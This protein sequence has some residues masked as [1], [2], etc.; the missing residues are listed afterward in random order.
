MFNI[1]HHLPLFIKKFREESF[2]KISSN[3]DFESA[4]FLLRKLCHF[5]NFD[6]CFHVKAAEAFVYQLWELESVPILF[7]ESS[8]QEVDFLLY[9]EAGELLREKLLGV[10]HLKARRVRAKLDRG[11]IALR[12]RLEGCN[13]GCDPEDPDESLLCR[14]IHAASV[15]KEGQVVFRNKMLTVKDKNQLR[16]ASRYPLFAEL[17][18]RD[19]EEAENF[20]TWALRDHIA[21]RPLIEFPRNQW[22]MNRYQLNGRL[23]RRGGFDLKVQKVLCEEGFE[24]VLTLPFEGK[25]VNILDE[26]KCVLFRGNYA[27]TIGEVFEIFDRKKI[28]AGNLE[29][30]EDGIMNWNAH[31]CGYWDTA[32]GDYQRI[33][34]A[35]SE[36]W[37]ELPVLDR[38]SLKKARHLFGSHLTGTEWNLSLISSRLHQDL[39]FEDAHGYLAISVPQNDGTYIVYTLGKFTFAF[40]GTLLQALLNIGETAEAAIAYPDENVFY[41]HRRKT[42]YSYAISEEDGKKFFE[43]VKRD[44]MLSREGN[45]IYQIESENCAKW[46]YEKLVYSIGQHRVPEIY[47]MPFL[48]SEPHGFMSAIFKVIKSLPK[49]W[50]I[51]VTTF[52]HFLLGGYK[53]R[54]IIENGKAVWKSLR[55]H[56]FW[57]DTVIFHPSMLHK[58]QE[59]GKI[60]RFVSAG[61]TCVNRAIFFFYSK[62]LSRYSNLTS[63]SSFLVFFSN[64]FLQ[65][66]TKIH[67]EPIPNKI[68]L[69]FFIKNL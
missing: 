60:G 39:N 30:M 51:P 43:S 42:Y 47:T 57:N 1:K 54:M 56:P 28:E 40:P 26:A 64:R 7:S 3:G 46:S 12:Y 19:E 35:K 10:H 17:V 5:F 11:L 68:S 55:Y 49:P 29:Y 36:W 21:V 59:E 13:G 31:Q 44:M 23:S 8:F 6:S 4:H 2:I 62:N 34:L 16:D 20:F 38:L 9:L 67:S 32:L 27:L 52:C 18:L 58:L 37:N 50:Q 45:L 22:K 66:F 69:C 63:F 61:I 15:W 24:K 41:T 25:P 48:H 33:D 53:G 14:L 65:I